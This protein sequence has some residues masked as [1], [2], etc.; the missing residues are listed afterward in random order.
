V[1]YEKDGKTEVYPKLAY[2]EFDVELAKINKTLGLDIDSEKTRE[3]A[4]KMGLVVKK[5]S[6]N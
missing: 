3:C 4:E 1:H 6:E 2:H 5:V